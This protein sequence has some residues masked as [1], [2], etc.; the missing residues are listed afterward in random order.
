MGRPGQVG[1]RAGKVRST[2]WCSICGEPAAEAV[3]ERCSALA[4]LE[5][6]RYCRDCRRRMVVQITPTGWTA[7]CSEHGLLTG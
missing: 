5:P 3:H 7:R 1:V 2:M 4:P 6:P